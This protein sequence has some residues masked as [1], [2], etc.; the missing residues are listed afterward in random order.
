MSRQVCI[1]AAKGST[2]GRIAAQAPHRGAALVVGRRLEQLVTRSEQLA[3]ARPVSLGGH[4]DAIPQGLHWP[5]AVLHH[6]L[7][8]LA[9]VGLNAAIPRLHLR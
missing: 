4:I 3:V 9:P 8:V 1:Q 5:V 2:N 6:A 7:T